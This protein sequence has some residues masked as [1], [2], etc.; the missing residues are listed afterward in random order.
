MTSNIPDEYNAWTDAALTAVLFAIDPDGIKGITLRAQPGPVRDA[1]LQHLKALFP[2]ENPWRRV[3]VNIPESRLLGGL[4]LTATLQAGRPVAE[5]GLL[6]DANGGVIE[7]AM[8]ERLTATTAAVLGHVIDAGAVTMERDGLTSK[9]ATRFGVIAL[10]EGIGDDEHAPAGLRERFAFEVDLQQVNYQQCQYWPFS[11]DTVIAARTCLDNIIFDDRLLEVLCSVALGLGIHSLRAPI[12]ARR[13]AC[14]IA[15]LEGADSVNEDHIQLACK[16]V[17]AHRATCVPASEQEQQDPPQPQQENRQQQDQ[18]EE[19]QQQQEPSVEDLQDIVLAATEAALSRQILEQLRTNALKNNSR[20]QSGRSN[21][22]KFSQLR[23]RPVGV[24][25]GDPANGARLSVIETLR[26]AA[27]WQRLRQRNT[28]INNEE[29]SI[30]VAKEDFRIC[31]FKQRTVTTTI[32]VVD[33]SGSAALHRLAEVKG[34]VEMLLAE[35]YQRRD[36]VALIA[37]RGTA[38]EL[39]LPPTRS[40]VRAKRLLA[41]LPGGGGTPLAAG[42]DA[43]VALAEQIKQRGEMPSIVLLTDGRANIDRAGNADRAKA[44]QEAISAA[45]QVR[46]QNVAA[47]L[48]DTSP[49]KQAFNEQVANAMDANYLA[50]PHADA[51]ALSSAVMGKPSRTGVNRGRKAVSV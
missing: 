21:N 6:A 27:P 12:I 32:F 43:A 40:L 11:A 24:R 17:F 26:A 20:N 45:Q 9:H 51:A 35:C 18:S 25:Q 48:I 50:L 15:A 46:L 23:G 31:R 4:D 34:A 5:R 10:D 49:R 16:L 1:W 47:L 37:F 33:A 7:L 28:A 44:E 14:A 38:A 8:A 29:N 42:I 19:D 2:V 30:A 13:V 39:V 3:P 41:G 36:Q 22:F